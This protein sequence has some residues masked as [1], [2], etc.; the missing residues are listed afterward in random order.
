LKYSALSCSFLRSVSEMYFEICTSQSDILGQAKRILAD[1]AEGGKETSRAGTA[2]LQ[3][4]GRQKCGGIK[5]AHAFCRNSSARVAA[6]GAAA[7]NDRSAIVADSRSRNFGSLKH[8]NGAA[9]R[10]GDNPTQLV[11]TEHVTNERSGRLEVWGLP[12]V[13]AAEYVGVVKPGWSVVE[14]MTVS[15]FP[16]LCH[17]SK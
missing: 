7:G 9:A 5:P 13:G 1:V 16:S 2:S 10:C 3:S 4:S 15:L 6:V 11:V 12:Y 17:R 14:T 8:R